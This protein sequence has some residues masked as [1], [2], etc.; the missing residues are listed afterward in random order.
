MNAKHVKYTLIES[1][2]GPL[3]ATAHEQA[4]TTAKW[5]RTKLKAASPQILA[6]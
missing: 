3:L 2:I 5:L 4:E 1:P 6:T